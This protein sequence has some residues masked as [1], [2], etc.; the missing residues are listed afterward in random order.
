ME[1]VEGAEEEG[2]ADNLSSLTVP[3]CLSMSAGVLIDEINHRFECLVAQR[4]V[5]L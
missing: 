1:G 2:V 3:C 4:G 5:A